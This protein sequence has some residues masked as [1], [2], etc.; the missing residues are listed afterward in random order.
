ML[1]PQENAAVMAWVRLMGAHAAMT[2]AFNA[3]LQA[4]CGL[5][6]TDFETLRR[7]AD[8]PEGLMRRVDL[9]QT[10]GLTASGITRLL[11]GL[12][13]A[14]LVTKE[15][16]ATDARVTYAVITDAGRATLREAARTHL[17]ALTALFGERFSAEEIDRL[18][19]LL[20]RL[21]GGGDPAP[22]CPT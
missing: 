7:L 11:D 10:I 9:A 17:A 6:V 16:C 5:T 3:D 12:Q 19:E 8:A 14:G 2:R 15:A 20:G 13:T 21:P 1:T 22:A 18:V 4:C